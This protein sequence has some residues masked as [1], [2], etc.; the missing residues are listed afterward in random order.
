MSEF[1]MLSERLAATGLYDIS[2]GTEVWAELMAYAA[3]LD[4]YFEELEEIR[5]EAFI[6]EA[7]SYGLELYE[8]L[9]S[10]YNTDTSLE[11]RRN[12]ILSALS[13]TAEDFTLESMNKLLGIYNIHGTF[14]DR[15]GDI[16][17]NCSDDL[18]STQKNA[19]EKHINTFA[20]MFTKIFV[21]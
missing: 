10:A 15:Y 20:P 18:T 1:Q 9:I 2:V 17:L 21:I 5:R 16:T 11:G 13:I 19:I 8:N 14:S 4:M 12:S 6:A 7:E 3:G